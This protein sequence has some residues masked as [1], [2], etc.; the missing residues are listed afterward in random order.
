[1]RRRIRAVAA[2]DLRVAAR[3]GEQLLLIVA[4]PVLFLVFFSQVSLFGDDDP[5]SRLVPSMMGLGLVG[6]AFTR[7]AISL[8]F[9]R[10]FGALARYSVT[11][12]RRREFLGA[13]GLATGLVAALQMVVIA[14]LGAALGWRPVASLSAVPVAVIGTIA[15]FAVGVILA[16]VTDGLRSLALANLVFVVVLLT[17]GAIAPLEEL[18][19]WLATASR[20]LPPTA[21]IEGLTA[22]ANGETVAG[23]VWINLTAWAVASTGVA[24]RLFRWR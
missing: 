21:L 2:S 22:A 18:P 15:L 10:A 11:P 14:G 20:L 5:V 8:G 19:T 13:K 12:L 17:C 1:M 16:S 6:S 24:A 3:D 7:T 9:D 23:W 4:I